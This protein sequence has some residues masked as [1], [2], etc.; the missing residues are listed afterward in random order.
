MSGVVSTKSPIKYRIICINSVTQLTTVKIK[1]C[2]ELSIYTKGKLVI[3]FILRDYS[4][5]LGMGKACKVCKTLT[6]NPIV[7][8]AIVYVVQLAY[9]VHIML[10][11]N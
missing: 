6:M 4:L 8:N 7:G 1:L 3:K 9:A 2:I 5:I 10:C 11:T